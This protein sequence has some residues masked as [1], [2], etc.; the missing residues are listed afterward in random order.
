MIFFGEFR[1]S[2]YI[3][4]LKYQSEKI[5]S[6]ASFN[7]DQTRPGHTIH[8]S[9]WILNRITDFFFVLKLVGLS[10][11]NINKKM[12]LSFFLCL[13]ICWVFIGRPKHRGDNVNSFQPEHKMTWLGAWMRTGEWE[14]SFFSSTIHIW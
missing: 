8:I 9:L 3:K 7:I 13:F 1:F 14:K 11:Y 6:I 4:S 12:F 5:N 2:I 10:Y